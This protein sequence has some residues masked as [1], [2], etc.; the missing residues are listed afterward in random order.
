[1]QYFL[2]SP[3]KTKELGWYV[4][5]IDSSNVATIFSEDCKV[6]AKAVM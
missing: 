2:H 3:E 1:M 6:E 5:R 4:G